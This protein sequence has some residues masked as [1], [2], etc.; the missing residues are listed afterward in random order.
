MWR[1]WYKSHAQNMKEQLKRKIDPLAIPDS[2]MFYAPIYWFHVVTVMIAILASI[3]WPWDL[4][5][6]VTVIIVLQSSRMY[7]LSLNR[8]I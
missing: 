6:T 3:Y 7:Y 4:P 1:V 5:A 8:S 2:M